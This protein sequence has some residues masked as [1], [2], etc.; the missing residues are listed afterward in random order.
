MMHRI[1]NQ[2]YYKTK[3][4]LGGAIDREENNGVIHKWLMGHSLFCFTGSGHEQGYTPMHAHIYV[5]VKCHITYVCNMTYTQLL[6]HY[7]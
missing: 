3:F 1:L 7:A 2:L 4:A 5:C 6:G